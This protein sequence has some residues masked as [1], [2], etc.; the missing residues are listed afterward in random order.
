MSLLRRID[1]LIVAPTIY[2][3]VLG[4]VVQYSIIFKSK[5]VSI[6]LDITTQ[7]FSVLLACL[8][9]Y[10]LSKMRSGFLRS[11]SG[12][13]YIVCCV[14]LV[15]VLLIGTEV[16]GAQRWVTIAGW[17]LQPTEIAK[18]ALIFLAAKSLDSKEKAVNRLR[19]V[20]LV[21]VYAA[22]PAGLVALQPDLGSAIVFGAIWFGML[23]ASKLQMSRLAFLGVVFSATLALSVPF[24]AEYQQ[25]RLVS[26]FNPDRDSSGANY[27]ANQARIAIG[28][29]GIFGSGLESGTQSQL[30][31]LPSQHTD[32][33]FAVTAEKLGIIGAGSV[34][35]AFTVLFTRG[36]YIAWI[37]DRTFERLV[38][39]GIIS[40]LFFHTFVNIGM[41]LGLMPVTGLPLPFLSYGGTFMVVSLFSVGILAVFS[42][43]AHKRQEE[44]SY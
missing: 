7:I 19:K 31:F 17:Q 34:L 2:L 10:V 39:V 25:E 28:T 29:G 22:V 32:F 40:L 9:I 38:I 11:V 30:N 16:N 43:R 42:S 24:L 44:Q 26:Y 20:A 35:V 36:L 33:I 18:L 3:V 8:S 27:N 41:N 1:W 15:L 6:D 5:G 14:L 12:S 37:T 13:F 4:L 23:F 21:L